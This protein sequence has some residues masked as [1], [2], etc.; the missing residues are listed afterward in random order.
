MKIETAFPQS[1]A[2]LTIDVVD[3]NWGARVDEIS[4]NL[5]RHHHPMERI[6][7]F[8]KKKKKTNECYKKFNEDKKG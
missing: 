1:F 3:S 8:L 6:G 2:Q 4:F 5:R 7:H